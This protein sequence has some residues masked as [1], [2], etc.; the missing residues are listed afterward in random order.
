MPIDAAIPLQVQPVRPPDAITS[1]GQLMQ[2]RNLGV[3][4]QLRQAQIAEANANTANIEAQA[5]QRQRDVAATNQLTELLGDPANQASVGKGDFAPFL[6]AGIPETVLTPFMQNIQAMQEKAQ[7]LQK[8]K[9]DFYAGGR[10]QLAD[11]IQGLDPAD[12]ARALAQWNE[13]KQVLASQHPEL[14]ATLPDLAPGPNFRQQLSD[15]AA[16]NGVAK[17][18]LSNQAELEKTREAAAASKASAAESTAKAGETNLQQQVLQHKLDLYNVLTKTPQALETRVAQSIN[19]NKYPALYQRAV[20]EAKNAPD[21]EGIN[22]AIGKYAQQASEQERQIALKTNPALADFEVN[23][24]GRRAQAE[25]N[26]L[27]LTPEAVQMAA[28]QYRATGIMPPV[29][30]NRAVQK[31]IMDAA[32]A[33]GPVDLASNEAAY[34]ANQGSLTS[35]QKN[36]DS[37]TA[38]EKTAGKNLDLFLNQA[39]KVVDTGSPWQ[40]APLRTIQRNALGSA[41]QAA[42][43]TARQVAIN[44]IAKVTGNPGLTGQLSDSARHEI[45]AFNPNSATLAQTYRVA[46]VLKQDMENRRGAYQDQISDIQ[47]RIGGASGISSAQSSNNQGAA[48]P[49]RA[50]D[51]LGIR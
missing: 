38:F 10:Q 27:S 29:G 35:L 30:R 20:N 31:Q 24:A 8:G 1:I 46:Q 43:D 40:N 22:N 32:A 36:L 14:A 18:I 19:P 12:D 4:R 15:I 45:E 50:S 26:A 37:V 51:P 16:S 11:T 33:M 2:L 44:E 28:A 6:S 41:D 17:S 13:A 42:Y 49:S 3:E 5:A 47:K 21:L 34:R 7:A 25:A 48:I 9:A 23:L 39:K